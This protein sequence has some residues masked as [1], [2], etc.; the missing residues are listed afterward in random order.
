MTGLGDD[1]SLVSTDDLV[2][3]LAA[4]HPEGCIVCLFGR[5]GAG[6]YYR[7]AIIG[8]ESRLRRVARLIRQ[9]MRRIAGG[10]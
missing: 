2:D 4:R 9:R 1:L 7:Y 3:E 5:E 10:E 8:I 6:P